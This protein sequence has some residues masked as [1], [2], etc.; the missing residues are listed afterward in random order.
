M[1]DLQ[2]LSAEPELLVPRARGS[3][4]SLSRS[5]TSYINPFHTYFG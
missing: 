5:E 3:E 4:A 2:P 1:K